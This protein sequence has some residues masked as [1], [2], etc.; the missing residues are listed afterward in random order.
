MLAKNIGCNRLLGPLGMGFICVNRV[1]NRRAIGSANAL[2]QLR[3]RPQTPTL[4]EN[5]AIGALI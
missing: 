4:C 3:A 2:L 1:S 5:I